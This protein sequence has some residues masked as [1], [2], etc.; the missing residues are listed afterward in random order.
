MSSGLNLPLDLIAELQAATET[1]LLGGGPTPVMSMSMMDSGSVLSDTEEGVE[2]QAGGRRGRRG[3]GDE[4]EG[5]KTT[6]DELPF[7]PL[8]EI[9]AMGVGMRFMLPPT[10]P[11]MLSASPEVTMSPRTSRRTNRREFVGESPRPRK[12]SNDSRCRC[13][14]G[15]LHPASGLLSSPTHVRCKRKCSR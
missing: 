3:G 11:P 9:E 7:V 5:G 14:D 2:L 1:T 13:S 12:F 10:A 6:D 4:M 15:G 8:P